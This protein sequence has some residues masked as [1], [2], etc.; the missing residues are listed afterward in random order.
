MASRKKKPAVRRTAKSVAGKRARLIPFDREHLE[1]VRVWMR[2]AETRESLGTIAP[3]SDLSHERWFESLQ[4]DPRRQTFAIAA[5]QPVGL[6]GLNSIDLVYRNAE[7]WIYVGDRTARRSG[8][9]RAA[10]EDLLD[11]AFDTLGLHRIYVRVFAFNEPAR[12]FFRACGFHDEGIDRE[13]VFKRAEFHD[14]YRL[15][16]LASERKR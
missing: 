12:K 13:A 7:L 14:V 10:V 2:D 4:T 5:P 15:A 9:G 1:R 11:F 3:P 8:A 16:I 6:A